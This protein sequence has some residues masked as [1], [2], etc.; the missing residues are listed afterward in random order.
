MQKEFIPQP[1]VCIGNHLC[2]SMNSAN[3]FFLSSEHFS[4]KISS[5]D[6]TTKVQTV[7]TLTFSVLGGTGLFAFRRFNPSAR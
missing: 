6:R 1:T 4:C 2:A 7:R 5:I 3:G